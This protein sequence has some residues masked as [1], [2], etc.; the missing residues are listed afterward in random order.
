MNN[1]FYKILNGINLGDQIGGPFDLASVLIDCIKKNNKFNK[2]DLFK[3][4]LNWWKNGAFDTGPTFASVFTKIENG[5]EY[6][7]AVLATHKQFDGNTAGCGPAHRASPFAG[8]DNIKTEKYLN[9]KRWLK[10]DCL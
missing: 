1:N 2:E 4:Y 9:L 6:D 7:E 3:K 8:F 5:M 10:L